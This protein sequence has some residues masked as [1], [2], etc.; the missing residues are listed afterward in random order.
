MQTGTGGVLVYLA[1]TAWDGVVGTDRQLVSALAESEPVLW[2]DPPVSI[3]SSARDRLRG[4]RRSDVG[5]DQVAPNT[6]RLRVFGP[7]GLTRRVLRSLAGFYLGIRIRQVVRATGVRVAAVVLATPEGRFPRR[8]PGRRVHYVTD[9]W[10]A[11]SAMMGLSRQRIDHLARLNLRDADVVAAVTPDLIGRLKDQ[12]GGPATTWLLLPNGCASGLF[13]ASRV[14]PAD[15]APREP[16]AIIVGQINERLDLTLL[17]A[18]VDRGITLVVVGPRTERDPATRK[19]LDRLFSRPSVRWLGSRGIEQLPRYLRAASVGLTPYLDNQFNRASF[20]LK[21][22][23]YLAAGLPVVASDLPATRWLDTDLISIA[24]CPDEFA[25]CVLAAVTRRD[26]VEGAEAPRR[27][28]FARTHSWRV[29]AD[30]LVAA[31]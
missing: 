17:N 6:C 9:D 13:E 1:G 10:P 15:D 7:P 23:E 18:V 31:L 3:L 8:V 12:G 4:S 29:R 20:P 5:F 11:G 25:E 21:T 2:V 16:F 27:M 22:L 30:S 19:E 24:R 28:E 14:S 26:G